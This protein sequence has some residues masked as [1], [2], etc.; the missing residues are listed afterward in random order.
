MK[1]VSSKLSQELYLDKAPL[2]SVRANRL[3]KK[4]K[5]P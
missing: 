5:A 1:S 2:G 3:L 4:K